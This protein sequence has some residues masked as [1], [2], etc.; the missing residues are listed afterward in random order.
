[1]V[2]ISIAIYAILMWPTSQGAPKYLKKKKILFVY[3]FFQLNMNRTMATNHEYYF[4]YMHIKSQAQITT[5]PVHVVGPTEH[6]QEYGCN[7][8]DK[9][10]PEILN[11]KRSE[12]IDVKVTKFTEKNYHLSLAQRDL[13]RTIMRP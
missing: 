1:M 13:A 8:M 12:N 4:V 5:G 9:H 6:E 3:G 11:I 7:V 2:Y 10:L